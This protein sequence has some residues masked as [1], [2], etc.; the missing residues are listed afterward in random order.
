M[1]IF[2]TK[3]N[4]YLLQDNTNQSFYCKCLYVQTILYLLQNDTEQ[5]ILVL[6]MQGLYC[7]EFIYCKWVNLQ[8]PGY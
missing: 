8:E 2:I 6:K 3:K 5:K 4:T 1:P 7:R